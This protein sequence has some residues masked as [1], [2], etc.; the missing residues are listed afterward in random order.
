MQK[1]IS[2]YRKWFLGYILIGFVIIS[3][4]CN[5][6]A[7]SVTPSL[8]GNEFLTTVQLQLVN[9]S[10]PSDVHLP[11]W[12]QMS[13]ITHTYQ[14]DSAYFNNAFMNLKANSTFD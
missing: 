1:I 2:L 7:S 12:S 10:D 8:P 3:D 5:K 9:A 14:T 13:P 4:G 11:S 6:K